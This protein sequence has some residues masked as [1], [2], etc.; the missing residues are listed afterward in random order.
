MKT[1]ILFPWNAD[2]YYLR[3]LENDLKNI[4][5]IEEIYKN[6]N[7]FYRVFRK[8]HLKFLKRY[9]WIWYGKWFSNLKEYNK[10][11]IFDSVIDIRIIDDILKNSNKVK[12]F[13]WFRNSI[14]NPKQ[15][16]DLKYLKLKNIEIW[17]FDIEDC[18]KYNLKYN[19]QFYFSVELEKKNTLIERDV[20]FIG[21]DKGRIKLLEIL[22]EIFYQQKIS[23]L[24]E[25]VRDR[26]KKYLKS[27]LKYFIKKV[28]KYE[29]ILLEIE[30]SKI[31]LEINSGNQSGLTLRAMESLF[32]NKKLISNNESLKEYDFYDLNNIFIFKNI[33][34]EIEELKIFLKMPYNKEVEKYKKNY[35]IQAWLERF[36][37]ND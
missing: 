13:F 10:I 8:I 34:E 7:F 20:Y 24:F 31:I 19:P 26:G 15:I 14:K 1:L 6:S 30:K 5:R 25:V 35:N 33:E 21:Y 4:D 23:F 28:K 18:K 29:E 16:N 37:K 32:Y 2:K 27:E 11:I 3:R 9:R 22:G 17:S 36:D 12:L